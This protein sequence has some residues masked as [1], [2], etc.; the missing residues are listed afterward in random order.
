MH[1]C[2]NAGGVKFDDK[3]LDHATKLAN[4]GSTFSDGDR[5]NVKH[6]YSFDDDH[7]GFWHEACSGKDCT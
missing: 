1:Y 3:A 2:S 7:R 4:K 5:A 6:L